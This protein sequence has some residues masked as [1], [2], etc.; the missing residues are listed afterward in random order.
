MRDDFRGVAMK[1]GQKHPPEGLLGD[2]E[3]IKEKV[4]K[5]GE[6]LVFI[7]ASVAQRRKADGEKRE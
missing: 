5:H 7:E 2:V 1:L 3:E 4:D 6:K